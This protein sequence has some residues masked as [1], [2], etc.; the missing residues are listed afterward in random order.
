MFWR[1]LTRKHQVLLIGLGLVLLGVIIQPHLAQ[2]GPITGGPGIAPFTK[3]GVYQGLLVIAPGRL[4]VGGSNSGTSCPLGTECQGGGVCT[5]SSVLEIGNAGRDIAGTGELY[6]RPGVLDRSVGLRLYRFNNRAELF[7]S[8]GSLCLGSV[9]PATCK[10]TWPASGGVGDTYWETFTNG[11]IT[12]LRPHSSNA[13][14]ASIRIG[15]SG[16]PIPST[17]GRALEIYGS[18]SPVARFT[19]YLKTGLATYNSGTGLTTFS[20]GNVLVTGNLDVQ[21][22]AFTTGAIENGESPYTPY[23]AVN[24]HSFGGPTYDEYGSEGTINADTF[25]SDT[26]LLFA[27]YYC[28]RGTNPG[29]SCV[30]LAGNGPNP[31]LCLGGGVCQKNDLIVSQTPIAGSGSTLDRLCLRANDSKICAGGT[32]ASNAGTPCPLGTGCTNGAV[33]TQMC[34]AQSATCA[35][36]PVATAFDPVGG[37]RCFGGQR[38]SQSCTTLGAFSSDCPTCSG[39]DCALSAKKCQ[40][41]PSGG[42]TCVNNSTCGGSNCGYTFVGTCSAYR[43]QDTNKACVSAADCGSA[44]TCLRGTVTSQSGYANSSCSGL[45]CLQICNSQT[46]TR[47][48][49]TASAGVCSTYG[50]VPQY[51]TGHNLITNIPFNSCRPAVP[52]G[53]TRLCDCFIDTPLQYNQALPPGN[54]GLLCTEYFS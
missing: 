34:S 35:V 42:A 15:R 28:R 52:L 16:S 29:A 45:T 36:D 20:G 9:S 7:V 33:C 10:S 12:S 38:D 53:W 4:C 37:F 47:C 44:G 13:N 21:N 39:P 41:G 19:G 24:R 32:A 27:S 8:S 17:S 31:S 6:I 22:V 30:N 49:G 14:P 50:G 2:A 40:G 5:V 51:S 23:T 43:C 48:D 18:G 26:N 3:L 46:V 1:Q 25:D 11:S 54:G